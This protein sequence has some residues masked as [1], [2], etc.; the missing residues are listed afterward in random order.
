VAMTSLQDRESLMIGG[1][2]GDMSDDV[3]PLRESLD[4][5]VTGPRDCRCVAHV[6]TTLIINRLLTHG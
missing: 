6:Q 5:H 1:D 4:S 2:H 3:T